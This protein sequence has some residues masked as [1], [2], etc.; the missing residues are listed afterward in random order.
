M[1]TQYQKVCPTYCVLIQEQNRE[2]GHYQ[3]GSITDQPARLLGKE[4]AYLMVIDGNYS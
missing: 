3:L 2:M 1:F 4:I